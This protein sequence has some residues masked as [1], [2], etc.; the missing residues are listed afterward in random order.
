MRV[1]WLYVAAAYM[2]VCMAERGGSLRGALEALQRRQR[3]RIHVPIEQPDYDTLYDFV[4]PQAYP[5]I[6]L[7]EFI[8]Y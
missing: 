5:G 3:G 8:L 1:L 7:L 4:P 2:V 6:M